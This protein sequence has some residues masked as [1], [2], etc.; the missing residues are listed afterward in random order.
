MLRLEN[1][2][3]VLDLLPEVGGA[4]GAF[5]VDGK[6]ILRRA[7]EGTRDVLL[8][9]CFALVPFANRIA[10]GTFVFRGETVRLPR[11]FGDHPHALHGQGWQNPWRV[12]AHASDSATLVYE[13]AADAWPWDYRA[14]QRFTLKPD[15]LSIDLR[16]TNCGARAMPVGLGFHPYFP[17]RDG[18]VLKTDVTGVW[19]SDA[20]FIPTDKADRAHFLDLA[21]GADLSRA[22][23]VDHCHFGWSGRATIAGD[24]D[25]LNLAASPAL[26]FLHLFLPRGESYFCAEPV[27]A[28]P[29]AVHR[30]A[31]ESGLRVLEP[32]TAFTVSMVLSRA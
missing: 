25:V 24:G 22:P 23:F 18:T 27:S 8:T 9:A 29:D 20:T 26:D 17:R 28:M 14:E 19:L 5:T 11:N 10:D 30:D 3:A 15:A 16:L 13:H 6:D 12:A 1:G 7:P 2:G 31:D 32:G 4:V 21:R